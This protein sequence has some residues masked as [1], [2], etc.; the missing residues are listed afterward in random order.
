MKK[1]YETIRENAMKLSQL[2]LDNPNTRVVAWIDSE[3]I[4]DEYPYWAGNLGK[5]E[6]MFVVYSE[7]EE[8][9]LEKDGNAYED[10]WSYYGGETDDWDDETLVS[11][12]VH[13]H[14]NCPICSHLRCHRQL[15]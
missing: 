14:N 7:I 1:E 12:L 9:W 13:I 11:R 4:N 10:C 3:G 6:K 15:A 2:I 8:H 5:P